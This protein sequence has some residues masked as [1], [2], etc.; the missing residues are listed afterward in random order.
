ML[1]DDCFGFL[2]ELLGMF[3]EVDRRGI[4]LIHTIDINLV[5]LLR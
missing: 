5:I 4:R 2:I 3:D 1:A